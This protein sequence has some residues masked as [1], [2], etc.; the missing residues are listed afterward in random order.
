MLEV[1]ILDFFSTNVKWEKQ[2]YHYINELK[3]IYLSTTLFTKQNIIVYKTMIKG[4]KLHMAAIKLWLMKSSCIS[5]WWVIPNW[6]HLSKLC[7]PLRQITHWNLPSGLHDDNALV[8][9]FCW[10]VGTFWQVRRTRIRTMLVLEVLGSTN[11]SLQI[12][13]SKS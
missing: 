10:A 3:R 8:V 2:K 6:I 11:I 1:L 12:T 4:I 9:Y 7:W 13:C 5:S